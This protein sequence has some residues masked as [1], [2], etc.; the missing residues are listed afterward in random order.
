MD[1]LRSLAHLKLSGYPAGEGRVGATDMS[2]NV[3]KW[4]ESYLANKHDWKSG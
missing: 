2:G 3:W 1:R 4:L